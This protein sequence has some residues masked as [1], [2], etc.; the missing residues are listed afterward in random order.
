MAVFSACREGKRGGGEEEVQSGL[1]QF[2]V[3]EEGDIQCIIQSLSWASFIS[4]MVSIYRR[5]SQFHRRIHLHDRAMVRLPP[6][7]QI[8][9]NTEHGHKARHQ[10][11]I[12]HLRRRDFP[13]FRPEAEEADD[14]Q[15]DAGKAVVEDSQDTWHVP[16]T[17]FLEADVLDEC[18]FGVWAERGGVADLTFEPPVEEKATD[19]EVGCVQRFEQQRERVGESGGAANVD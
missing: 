18:F 17:P 9:H 13:L 16:G 6:P 10:D 5:L 8:I 1:D 19:Q 12:V 2:G 4:Y 15:I 7:Q 3:M 14:D 11:T